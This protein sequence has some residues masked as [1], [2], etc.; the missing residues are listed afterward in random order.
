MHLSATLDYVISY[1]LRRLVVLSICVLLAVGF[2]VTPLSFL[3]VLGIGPVG[4]R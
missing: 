2:V 1:L 4:L 3:C